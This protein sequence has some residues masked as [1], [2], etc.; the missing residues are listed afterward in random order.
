MGQ[1]KVLVAASS[2][3]RA[4]AL[5]KSMEFLDRGVDAFVGDVEPTDWRGYRL[6][7]FELGRKLP[8]L[9]GKLDK[10][11]L[12]AHVA[13]SPPRLDVRT[14]VHY[15]QDPRVNHLLLRPL[16]IGDLQLIADKLGSGSIFGLERHLPPQCEVVYR[17]LSTFAER[18]DAIDDLEAYARK[19]RLR[20][21]IRRNAV[22]VAEELLMNAMY[23]APVDSQGERI[24]ANVDPHAR[25]SQRTPRP[26]SIRYA[27]H[28]R[29]LYLSVRDRF[30]SFRRD[31]LVRYLTRC[32]TEQVQIEEKK[33]G[34]GLGLYLIA[35]TVNRMVINL[36]PG[37][38]SE[39]ICTFEP[40]QAGEPSGM[41]LFS[42]TAHRP[43]PA[44]PL[45]PALEPGW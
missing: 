25:V 35:S 10:L 32:V 42:F 28:D 43:R 12:K 8:T 9:D 5:R 13:V 19:R 4:R 17:R 26:V 30:G 7:V 23:Q 34:A 2:K 41:R 36:L 16:D 44:P 22:R 21:L 6:A 27:V 31:D 39:F 18:C 20:S 14:V 29:H 45:E 11:S 37:S 24:F 3:A 40:P 33:L 15:M 1:A 38:V